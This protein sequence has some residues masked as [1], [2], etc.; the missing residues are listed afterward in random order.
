MSRVAKN[1]AYNLLGQGLLLILGFVAVRYVFVR[2]GSEALGVIYF[3]STVSAVLCALMELGLTTTVLREVAAHH[4]NDPGYVR[5]LVRTI[6]LVSWAGAVAAAVALYLLS[7]YLVNHWAKLRL[8]PSGVAIH[9]LRVLGC[10]GLLALPRTLYLALLRGV[11]R[12]EFGNAIDVAMVGA[13]QAGVAAILAAGGGLLSASYWLALWFLLATVAYLIAAAH[14]VSFRAL[15]PGY[16]RAAVSRVLGFSSHMASV[17]LLSFTH[18]QAARILASKLLPLGDFGLYA[19]ASSLVSRGSVL[20][21]AVSQ[22]G[23]PALSA[24]AAHEDGNALVTQYWKLQE[25]I[26]FAVA[27]LLAAVPFAAL[28]LFSYLLNE[29]AARRLLLP[30]AWLALGCMMSA[31]VAV[32]YIFLVALGKPGLMARANAYAIFVVLPATGWLVYRYGL[33]GAAASWLIYPCFH[34]VYTIP[35]ICSEC[36]HVRAPEWYAHALRVVGFPTLIFGG[37]WA[38]AQWRGASLAVLVVSYTAC[39]LLFVAV[40]YMTLRQA[41]REPLSRVFQEIRLR[42]AEAF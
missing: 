38:V 16:S 19:F 35:R 18:S 32:P 12:M 23:F 39:L 34:Y 15:V 5:D 27:P 2:L 20:V 13:Q 14:F 40:S 29:G 30:T 26:G 31:T 41:M 9:A 8:L 36:L 7:P 22:A 25:V 24:S 3:A 33:A 17:S 37:G 10:G 4:D 21:D 28:P 6:S 11:Q 42:M 1:I